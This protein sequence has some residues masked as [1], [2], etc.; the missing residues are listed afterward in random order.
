MWICC[1]NFRSICLQ[2]TNHPEMSM[3][4]GT[5]PTFQSWVFHHTLEQVKLGTSNLVYRLVVVSSSVCMIAFWYITHKWGMF[6]V[7]WLLYLVSWKRYKIKTQLQWITNRKSYVAYQ[8]TPT[9]KTLNLIL[10]F[11]TFL[12]PI[13]LEIQHVLTVTCLRTNLKACIW[14]VISTVLSELIG[15]VRVTGSPFTAKVVISRKWCQIRTLL[16]YMIHQIAPFPVT[17]SDIQGHSPVAS[18]FKCNFL[19]S[20]VFS[21]FSLLVWHQEEHAAYKT[22]IDEVLAWLF[23]LSYVRLVYVWSRWCLCYPHRLSPH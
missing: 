20:C 22:L 4:E 6:K 13:P 14:P 2:I 9:P 10:L 8:V 16:L 12:T 3:V 1:S 23:V 11:A 18:L 19:Y 7:M 17:L 15:I 21:A 5:W